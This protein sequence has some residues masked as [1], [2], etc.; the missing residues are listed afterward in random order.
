MVDDVA[1]EDYRAPEPQIESVDGDRLRIYCGDQLPPIGAAVAIF[2]DD[3]DESSPIYAVVERHVGARRID[4]W[5]PLRPDGIEAG[6]P[7][8]PGDQPAGFSLPPSDEP[9]VFDPKMVRP[10]ADGDVALWPTPPDWTQLD[11]RREALPIGIDA[12]DTL[13]PLCRGGV[14][15]L[16]DTS[17]DMAA[18]PRIAQRL[19]KALSPR[20]ILVATDRP[21]KYS[22]PTDDER[23]R[24]I[25]SPSSKAS[26]IASLQL[27]IALASRL[28]NAGPAMAVIDLPRL[29]PSHDDGDSA[30]TSSP[31]DST[32][33]SLIDR[34][35][36]HLVSTDEG[37]ITTLLVLRLPAEVPGL[38]EIV[39]TLDLGD[40]DATIHID[41][42]GRFAPRRSTS[43]AELDD[44]LQ[45]RRRQ[46]LQTLDRAQRA[47]DKSA[48]LGDVE[49]TDADRSALER[50]DQLHPEL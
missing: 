5:L 19:E 47:R 50:A 34:L 17:E 15:L 38:A 33:S 44:D 46:L 21:K 6:L 23:L 27:V 3:G 28:R 11:P 9:L 29:H 2:A 14:N 20:A 16:I 22:S 7:V 12:V 40:V 39:E 49:L 42:R 25:D 43:D 30:S 10:A 18:S 36:R 35:G 1:L 24:R 26:H 37:S 4:A 31:A 48:L 41:V 45:A 13:A 8:E 32:L